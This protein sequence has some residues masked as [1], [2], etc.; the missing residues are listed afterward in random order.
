MANMCP[1][2]NVHFLWRCLSAYIGI[3]IDDQPSTSRCLSTETSSDTNER[4]KMGKL[5]ILKSSINRT[6]SAGKAIHQAH[7]SIRKIF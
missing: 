6:V 2:L 4:K 3:K 5:S 1:L 7:I